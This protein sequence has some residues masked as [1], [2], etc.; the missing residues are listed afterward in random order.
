MF[1]EN[2]SDQ[3]WRMAS[4][5]Q[6]NS[7]IVRKRKEEADQKRHRE[8]VNE[9]NQTTQR[10]EALQAKVVAE[11]ARSAEQYLVT[12]SKNNQLLLEQNR[13]SN[14]QNAILHAIPMVSEDDRADFITS[15]LIEFLD[16]PLL[17]FR[18]LV[19]PLGRWDSPA[20]AEFRSKPA[21]EVAISL[22][23]QG[24]FASAVERVQLF[25][26]PQFRVPPEPW[27]RK[28][29][30]QKLIYKV[31]LL[32]KDLPSAHEY[33]KHPLFKAL[34][35]AL[36]YGNVPLEKM[37]W[38]VSSHRVDPRYE[39]LTDKLCYLEILIAIWNDNE[40]SQPELIKMMAILKLWQHELTDEEA[41]EMLNK[42]VVQYNSDVK[43]ENQEYLGQCLDMICYLAHPEQAA[44]IISQLNE[45]AEVD[46]AASD[47]QSNFLKQ[48]TQ[49]YD[50]IQSEKHDLASK[51]G[52]GANLSSDYITRPIPG[53]QDLF[54]FEDRVFR[55]S[56]GHQVDLS[57]EEREWLG[58]KLPIE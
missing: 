27:A 9:Q 37:F 33:Y 31:S 36:G 30:T 40:I 8:L 39:L 21:E 41:Y 58:I 43:N 23:M 4:M 48:L 15:M 5:L 35:S 22:I 14:T 34:P 18:D 45:L 54:A 11:Q 28:L 49:T 29:V 19:E 12:T 52:F 24:E 55:Y 17:R 16:K 13:L 42:M 46:M 44:W 6:M 3:D 7:N 38:E 57:N 20:M 50:N 25:L 51:C 53:P 2:M 47:K 1:T 56:N 26:P 32:Q 10:V